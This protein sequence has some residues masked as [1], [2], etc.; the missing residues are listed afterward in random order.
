MPTGRGRSF[1]QFILEE[2]EGGSEALPP[3]HG[4][5]FLP[6]ASLILE[7]TVGKYPEIQAEYER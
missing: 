3:P 6:G 5:S 1:F 4:W 7:Y 2:V